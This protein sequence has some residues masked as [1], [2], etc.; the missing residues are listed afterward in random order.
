LFSIEPNSQ[1]APGKPQPSSRGIPNVL[2]GPVLVVQWNDFDAIEKTIRKD[3]GNISA[4]IT[5]PIM[6]NNAV[7]PPKEGYLRFLKDLCEKDHIVLIF[8]EVKTGFRV[9]KGGAQQLFGVKSHLSTFANALGNGYPISAVVGLK[10]IMQNYANNNVILY[11]GTYA[12]N[13]VSLAAADVRLDQI[14]KGYAQKY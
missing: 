1:A 6:A 2:N 4:I 9:A 11:Q 5:E 8:N 10:D 12:R 14:K 7:I 3:A 13:P